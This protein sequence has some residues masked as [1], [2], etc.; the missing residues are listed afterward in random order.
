MELLEIELKARPGRN[1]QFGGDVVGWRYG[2]QQVL[3]QKFRHCLDFADVFVTC[4]RA[5][6]T[7][8]RQVAGWPYGESGHEWAEGLFSEGW[9]QFDPT[10]GN[11]NFLRS[12]SEGASIQP[13]F[14]GG[15]RIC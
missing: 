8:S 6:G 5:Q 3:Q 11:S 9:R 7:L 12:P 10:S 4:C 13:R 15:A 14:A 2:V 1:I